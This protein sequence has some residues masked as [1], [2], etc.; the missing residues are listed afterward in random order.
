MPNVTLNVILVLTNLDVPIVKE[1]EPQN[2]IVHVQP[3]PMKTTKN[4]VQIVTTN[5]LLVALMTTT[6]TLVPLTELKLQFVTVQPVL[7]TL[8]DKLIVQLVK[9]NVKLVLTPLL[10]VLLV[11]ETES[12][13]QN[14]KSQNQHHIPL[15][16]KTNH[17]DLPKLLLVP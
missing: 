4:N 9:K 1:T 8:K 17:S 12:T 6:V 7:I 11:L 5:V 2:Q 14:V 16:L 3:E 10:T 13:H 15:L